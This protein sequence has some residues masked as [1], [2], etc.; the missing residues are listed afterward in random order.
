MIDYVYTF[1]YQHSILRLNLSLYLGP[2]SSVACIDLARLQ[3][4]SECA[5]QSAAGRRH[6]IVESRCV[7]FGYIGR[8]T[9]MFGYRSVH[10]KPHRF[11]FSRQIGQAQ[12]PSLPLNTNIRYIHY[13]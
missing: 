3:R 11:R 7:R 12:W 13:F 10:A 1:D 8:H 6:D 5:H 2:Q 9:V 4:A